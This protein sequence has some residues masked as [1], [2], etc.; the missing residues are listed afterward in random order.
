MSD[1]D[2]NL[3]EYTDPDIY[4]QENQ[5]FE[6]EGPF[7]LNLARQVGGEVLELGCGTGRITIPLAQQGISITGVDLAPAML[8]RARSKAAALRDAEGGDL[9]LTWLQADV[10]SLH[11]PGRRF[12]LIFECG[13]VFQHMHTR[14]DQEALLARVAEHLAA[15]GRFVFTTFF[16]SLEMLED[17]PEEKEWFAYTLPDGREV[18]VSGTEQYDPLRQLKTETAYRRWVGADGQTVTRIA[19][20][21][22]RYIFPQEME[23]LLHYNGFEIEAQYADCERHLLTAESLYIVYVCVSSAE[24]G[25]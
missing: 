13:S 23:A 16:P 9:P 24:G 3:L 8:E 7:L 10:R 17:V 18:R 25:I 1:N 5:D 4:D 15:G 19:P 14:P 20:L 2:E 21:T 6:P 12:G 22:L 11:L